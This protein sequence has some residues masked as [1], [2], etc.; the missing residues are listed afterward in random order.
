[1]RIAGRLIGIGAAVVALAGPAAANLERPGPAEFGMTPKQ[2]VQ[3]IERVES[4]IAACM[5][6]QGFQYVPVDYATVRKGMSAIGS[7]G[8]FGE[9]VRETDAGA[10]EVGLRLNRIEAN[11][12]PVGA[13]G[14]MGMMADHVA[15]LADDF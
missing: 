13:T 1:M 7:M 15:Q 11:A 4:R 5:R 12:G 9:W 8:V 6:E 3:A 10:V 2:L 14:M